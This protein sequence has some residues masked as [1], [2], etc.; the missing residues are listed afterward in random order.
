MPKLDYIKK[1]NLRHQVLLQVYDFGTRM[2]NLIYKT[3]L[4]KDW[5]DME[6]YTSPVAPKCFRPKIKHDK[7]GVQSI[8][9]KAL[10]A[11]ARNGEYPFILA[12]IIW[13]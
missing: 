12:Q 13:F 11:Y 5:T 4:G 8:S 10:I 6:A 9:I 3:S 2:L 1:V 7:D